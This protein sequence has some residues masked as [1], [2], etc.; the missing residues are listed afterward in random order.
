M[1]FINL[2]MHMFFLRKKACLKYRVW[3]VIPSKQINIKLN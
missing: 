1:E 2:I 3:G